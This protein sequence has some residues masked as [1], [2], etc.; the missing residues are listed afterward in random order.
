MTDDEPL[1]LEVGGIVI[2]LAAP[3]QWQAALAACYAGFLSAGPAS[4]QVTLR[5][6]WAPEPGRSF[7]VEHGETWTCLGNEVYACWL[8][9]AARAA[10]VAVASEDP[11]CL[12]LSAFWS[13]S[14][15]ESCHTKVAFAARLWCLAPWAG[16][17]S[18]H[19]AQA[20]PQL[21]GWPVAMARY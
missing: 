18:G 7:Y 3:V 13:T 9:M 1:I 8:D 6:D 17:S 15:R 2:A 21:R 20:K 4:W 11:L 5:C 19:R 16:A 14:A 12:L 10:V